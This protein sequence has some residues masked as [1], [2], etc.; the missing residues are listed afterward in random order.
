MWASHINAPHAGHFGRKN[1]RVF[2][3][4]T[5]SPGCMVPPPTPPGIKRNA[6]HNT[7]ECPALLL[8]SERRAALGHSLRRTVP[9]PPF[10]ASDQDLAFRYMGAL[11]AALTSRRNGFTTAESAI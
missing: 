8:D 7:A 9:E 6:A 5:N 2:L 1:G 11:D 3:R 10:A 4:G